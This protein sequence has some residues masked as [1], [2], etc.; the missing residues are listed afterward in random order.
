M[1]N[2]RKPEEKSFDT[3][4]NQI[5]KIIDLYTYAVEQC[6]HLAPPTTPQKEAKRN[7]MVSKKK[8]VWL[9][10]RQMKRKTG[11]NHEEK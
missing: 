8:L 6:M 2:G 11:R 5:S 3:V 4:R 10:Y 9:N 7:G 1:K